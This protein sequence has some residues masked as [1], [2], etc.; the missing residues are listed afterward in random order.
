MNRKKRRAVIAVEEIIRES[1][2]YEYAIQ[3]EAAADMS[4]Y[5]SSELST[6]AS[7]L[8]THEVER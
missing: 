7:S 5:I 3:E 2:E 4:D 1:H 8:Q 6:E